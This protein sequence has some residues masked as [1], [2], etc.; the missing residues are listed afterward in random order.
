LLLLHCC[1]RYYAG[2]VPRRLWFVI[3]PK[4]YFFLF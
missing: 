4:I 3:K 1:F 2:L